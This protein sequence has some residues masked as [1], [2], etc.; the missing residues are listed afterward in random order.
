MS[1]LLLCCLLLATISFFIKSLEYR[2][3]MKI[4]HLEFHALDYL[5]HVQVPI[6]IIILILLAAIETPSSF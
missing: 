6:L 3:E 1:V 2:E 4:L 5:K